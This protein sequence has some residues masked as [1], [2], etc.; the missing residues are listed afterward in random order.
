MIINQNK[1]LEEDITLPSIQNNQNIKCPNKECQGLKVVNPGFSFSEYIVQKGEDV[2]LIAKKFN[3]SSYLI[4]L[5]NNLG[6][7]NDI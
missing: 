6:F 5:E 3:L 4:L 7:Y 2:E 1:F